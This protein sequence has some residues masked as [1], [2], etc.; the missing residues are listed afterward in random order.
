MPFVA[1]VALQAGQM[2]WD[3]YARHIKNPD[4]LALCQRITT[5]IDA[6]AEAEF[7]DNMA[8]VARIRTSQGSFTK[9]VKIPKGEPD[10]FLS[11]TEL[12]AK[13]DSLTGPFLSPANRARLA[14]SLLALETQKNITQ[15]LALTR[16]DNAMPTAAGEH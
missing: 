13:F 5:V 8:G 4:T 1:A 15:L 2:T 11:T 12:R 9:W 10:N 3:D 14:N 16:P 7:P 6:E